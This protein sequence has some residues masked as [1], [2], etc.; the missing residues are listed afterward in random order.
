MIKWIYAWALSGIIGWAKRVNRNLK[1]IIMTEVEAKSNHRSILLQTIIL[2]ITLFGMAIAADRRV[3]TVE[4][5]L[6]AE[7]E[8]RQIN[9]RQHEDRIKAIESVQASSVAN[10]TR[11]ITLIE[12]IE[13]RHTLE[14]QQRVRAK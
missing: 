1:E 12:V 8:I 14:D 6:K 4:N 3:T 5:S 9:T 11:L 10:E 2:V 13:K 7:V